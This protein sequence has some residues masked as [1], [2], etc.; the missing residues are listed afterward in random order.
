MQTDVNSSKKG[1]RLRRSGVAGVA[2]GM[3]ALVACELPFILTFIGLGSLGAA[4][5]SFKPPF[6][7]ELAGVIIVLAGLSLLSIS[8]TRRHC[9]T[10]KRNRP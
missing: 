10:K 3:L 6:Y 8:A 9:S 2:L 5:S 4:A 1:P 7:V